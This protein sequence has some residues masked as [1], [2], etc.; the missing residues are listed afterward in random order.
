[1]N[2]EGEEEEDEDEEEEEWTLQ[3]E[4][5]FDKHKHLSAEKGLKAQLYNEDGRRALISLSPQLEKELI[6]AKYL[7]NVSS[8]VARQHACQ[9]K[10]CIHNI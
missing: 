3:D 4:A 9:I 1:M 5:R 8:M 6:A 2:G 7:P 10:V